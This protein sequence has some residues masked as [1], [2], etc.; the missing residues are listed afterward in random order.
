M[1]SRTVRAL[2]ACAVAVLAL[3]ATAGEL[4]AQTVEQFYRG[5]S[6]Q[7]FI[8]YGAGGIADISARFV[9]RHL[10]RFIPGNPNI[11]VQNRPGGAA[12]MVT[13]NFL[14]NVAPKDGTVMA[15]IARSAPQL[16]IQGDPNVKFESM[17]FGWLG[18]I[19]S[20]ADDAYLLLLNSKHPA[21]TVADLKKPG[22][23][24]RLGASGPGSTNLIF[25][26][27]A[28]DVLGLQISIV[29]GYDASAR[30]FLA[31]DQGE[32]DGLVILLSS[33]K[34]GQPAR[35]KNNQVRPLIQFARTARLPEIGEI[36]TGRELLTNDGDRALVAF[37]EAPFFMSIPFAV[38]PGVPPDRLAAL[39]A[40]FM[41]MCKDPEFLAEAARIK[42]D[43]S[44]IDGETVLKL[45]AEQAGTPKDVV[46]RYD[47]I[48]GN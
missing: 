21:S 16:E 3:T 33:V 42:L 41:A 45:I 43:I 28:K 19:S 40:A 39:R 24:A 11:I 10:A 32:I 1:I 13:T 6:V 15:Q 20:G 23:L 8:G 30:M 27:I 18:S 29:R 46:A 17:R 7:L 9:A 22:V 34:A 31:M 35:W 36:P 38:P 12:G 47:R 2:S 48:T 4:A 5:R 37:A 26:Q 25:A 44:P 14:Y